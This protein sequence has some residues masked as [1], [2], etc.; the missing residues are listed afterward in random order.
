MSANLRDV[1]QRA[2]TPLQ[3]P[4]GIAVQSETLFAKYTGDER[5]VRIGE[6]LNEHNIPH[7]IIGDFDFKKNLAPRTHEL[8]KHA[9]QVRASSVNIQ[10]IE[11][12]AER[13]ARGEKVKYPPIVFVTPSGRVVAAAGSHRAY[14]LAKADVK[15]PVIV[16]ETSPYTPEETKKLAQHIASMTNTAEQFSQEDDRLED[17]VMQCRRAYE[18]MMSV[19][20]NSTASFT[21]G[22]QEW[23]V[24]MS[25]ASSPADKRTLERAWFETWMKREKPF[26]F[27]A[28]I[29]RGRIFNQV[30]SSASGMYLSP[31]D[32]YPPDVLQE[33]FEGKFPNSTWEPSENQLSATSNIHQMKANWTNKDPTQHIRRTVHDKVFLEEL[34]LTGP[35]AEV[36]LVVWGS[37]YTT[38]VK[39]RLKQINSVVDKMRRDNANPRTALAGYPVITKILFPQALACE[40]DSH[41]AY[42]W[43][44]QTKEFDEV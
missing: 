15:S 2:P 36:W 19:D 39:T 35:Q 29:P 34:G 5:Y 38:T 3:T 32:E 21:K 44:T 6:Y 26:S 24:R 20:L 11:T 30:F 8:Y 4:V 40:E 31:E 12:Y 17:V 43:N 28:K 1:S 16:V 14:A 23:R 37:T 13:F 18:S 7:G 27:T 22:D 9:C 41:I 25:N 33:I 10:R 42:S